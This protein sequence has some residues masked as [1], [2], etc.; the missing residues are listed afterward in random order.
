MTR[1]DYVVQAQGATGARYEFTS[2]TYVVNDKSS[3]EQISWLTHSH[4]HFFY[5][6][7]LR[8]ALLLLS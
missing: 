3:G 5:R 1:S 2:I 4:C 6:A 7:M 8:R